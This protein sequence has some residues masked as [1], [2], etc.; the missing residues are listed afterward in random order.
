MEIIVLDKNNTVR[1][2]E[3]SSDMKDGEWYRSEKNTYYIRD[4][5]G[6]VMCIRPSENKFSPNCGNFNGTLT[7]VNLKITIEEV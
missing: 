6:D 1:T 4:G 3:K 2:I 5:Y 7:P